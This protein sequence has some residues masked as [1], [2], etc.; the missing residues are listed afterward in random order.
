VAVTTRACRRLRFYKYLLGVGER[1]R[2]IFFPEFCMA[3][4][5]S[6]NLWERKSFPIWL[7]FLTGLAGSL[8]G[9]YLWHHFPGLI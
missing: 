6:I 2:A 5:Q 9:N 4:D 8:L 3:H 1:P 7:S